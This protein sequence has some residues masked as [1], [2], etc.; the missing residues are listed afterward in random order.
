VIRRLAQVAR[1]L[2]VILGW[3]LLFAA[4]AY[5]GG[6]RLIV[7]LVA[8]ASATYAVACA[9]SAVLTSIAIAG[10]LVG[11]AWVLLAGAWT[12]GWLITYGVVMCHAVAYLFDVHR[13]D[14]DTRRPIHAALYMMQLPVLIAGPLS[15]YRDFSAQ[16]ARSTLSLGAFAYGMRRVVTGL[17]KALL[18]GSVLAETVNAIYAA[19]IPRLTTGTAWL[20]AICF[21]LQVYLQF[22]GYCDVGIG[23]GRMI[24]L[25]YSENYRRPYTADSMREFWRRWNVTLI[26]WLRDYLFLPIAGQDAPT[27]RLFINIVAGFCLIGLWHGGASTFL[28]WGVYSGSWLALEAVGLHARVE[29]LPRLLRHLYVLLV[30]VVGWV[31]LRAPDLATAGQF[32][33]AMVGMNEAPA[34]AVARFTSPALWSALAV[35]IYA[36]GPPVP[37]I[38]RWRVSI[39]AATTSLLMMIAATGVFLWRGPSLAIRS[40]WPKSANS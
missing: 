35:G 40:I 18:I 4:L 38:S 1:H 26:T 30:M 27:P 2:P 3:L 16:L 9:E 22:S 7:L 5:A 20:G 28:V 32:L 23:I 19:P 29:R 10:H 12:V 14:A 24:G 17:I 8:I 39:D 25:R 34:I 37:S 31:I 6:V 15:R 33:S 21:S 11:F 36:A 13:G